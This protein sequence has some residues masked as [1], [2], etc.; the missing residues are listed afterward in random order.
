MNVIRHSLTKQELKFRLSLCH[1]SPLPR[2]HKNYQIVKHFL[3]FSL[4]LCFISSPLSSLFYLI[5]F[6]LSF[7]ISF[8][9]SSVSS[10][11]SSSPFSYKFFIFFLSLSPPPRYVPHIVSI[12]CFFSPYS[13]PF[14][15]FLPSLFCIFSFILFIL[16]Y[17]FLSFLFYSVLFLFCLFLYLFFPIFI[18]II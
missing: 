15:S 11:V 3:Y 18:Q 14:I 12:S 6:H 13:N 9:F 7:S 1:I 8:S 2:P 17:L 4:I 5:Y 10:S 16:S